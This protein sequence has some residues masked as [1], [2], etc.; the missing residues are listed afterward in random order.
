MN[1]KEKVGR[2]FL[3]NGNPTDEQLETLRAAMEAKLSLTTIGRSVVLYLLEERKLLRGYYQ[4]TLGGS[5][6]E[7]RELIKAFDKDPFT[8]EAPLTVEPDEIESRRAAR[9]RENVE[10]LRRF[11]VGDTVRW[12]TPKNSKPILKVTALNEAAA[13]VM[14]G[15]MGIDPDALEIITVEA[16]K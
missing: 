2:W 7:A 6:A 3:E 13:C 15:D 12:L 16:G 10:K 1:E 14:C 5:E 4:G 8:V 9:M 11:K